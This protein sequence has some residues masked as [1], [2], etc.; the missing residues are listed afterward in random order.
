LR[1]ERL[2]LR[3]VL[4]GVGRRFRYGAG[5]IE[6]AARAGTGSVE[7]HVW[8]RGPGFPEAFLAR[9]S[10]RRSSPVPSSASAAPRRVIAMGAVAWGWQSSKPSLKPTEERRRWRIA[11]GE[12]QMPG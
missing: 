1:L 6:L 11:R 3:D 10:P 7:I 9:A 5:T 4:E 12:E 2:S 8:D